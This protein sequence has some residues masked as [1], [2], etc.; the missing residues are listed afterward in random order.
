MDF[1]LI[2]RA[3]LILMNTKHP[4]RIQAS[5]CMG[6]NKITASNVTLNVQ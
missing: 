6:N 3:T 4:M 2:K 1:N 5:I